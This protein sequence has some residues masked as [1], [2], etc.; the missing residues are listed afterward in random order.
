MS[1]SVELMKWV[2]TQGDRAMFIITLCVCGYFAYRLNRRQEGVIDRMAEDHKES[3]DAHMAKMEKC[4]E[5]MFEQ[6]EQV[7]AVVSANT[8]A[9]QHNTAVLERIERKP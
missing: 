4:T 5:R 8:A 6:S 3:R 1:E 2:S 9:L 7:T